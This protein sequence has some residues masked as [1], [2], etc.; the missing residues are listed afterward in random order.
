MPQLAGGTQYKEDADHV[1]DIVMQ[2]NEM[3]SNINIL[4]SEMTDSMD[5]IASEMETN[6]F[7]K[8]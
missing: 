3:S 4:V 6:R 2:F 1:N 7:I 8:L 5:G